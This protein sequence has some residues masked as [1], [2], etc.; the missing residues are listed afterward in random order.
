MAE[1]LGIPFFVDVCDRDDENSGRKYTL[2]KT[3]EDEL[4]QIT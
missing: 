1:P 3:P 2:D 4:G